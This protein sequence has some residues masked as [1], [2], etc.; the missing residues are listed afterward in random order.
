MNKIHQI[1]QTDAYFL[2]A[3]LMR[4]K[5]SRGTQKKELPKED[6]KLDIVSRYL[7]TVKRRKAQQK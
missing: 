4:S 5:A 3:D 2:A 7:R 6:V 1:N